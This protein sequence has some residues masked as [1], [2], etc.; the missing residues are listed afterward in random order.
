VEGLRNNTKI[1]WVFSVTVKI[2][3]GQVKKAE[4][5]LEPVSWAR[6]K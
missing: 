4:F 3:T 6:R 1:V 5:L 2:R